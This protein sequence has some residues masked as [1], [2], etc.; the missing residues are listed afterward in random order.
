[1][2]PDLGKAGT[3]Y[4]KTVRSE[5]KEDGAKPDPSLLFDCVFPF[6][7]P[8]MQVMMLT[9]I[10][11]KKK[12]LMA[13]GSSFE[14]NP[15]GISSMLLYHASIIT[16]GEFE[17]E[18]QSELKPQTKYHSSVDIFRTNRKDPTISD[19][20]SYLDLAPLY[21]SNQE[22]QNKIRTFHDGEI[23]PDTFSEKRLL[24]FPPGVNC[25]LVMYSRFHNYAARTLA[26]I[27]AGGRFSVDHRL[28]SEE[29]RLKRDNNIFQV[30]RL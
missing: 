15:A 20:S 5:T 23:K 11:Q 24:A 30:A 14:E 22:Q 18:C 3:P 2:Y 9:W 19:T 17:F 4:A 26:A 16:H 12:V 25:M 13:R 29:A 8:L 21:G 7:L 28:P 10:I 6:Y 1:M 27:N